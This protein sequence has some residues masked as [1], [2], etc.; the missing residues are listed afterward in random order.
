[1]GVCP[2]AA[3]H[4]AADFPEIVLMEAR[5]CI[6]CG[7]CA[8]VCPFDAITYHPVAAAPEKTAVAIKCD[9]CIE[10]QRQ[11]MI[12][13]CVESCKVEALQFGE[14]NELV[15]A[16]RTRYSEAVSVAMVQVSSEFTPLP[17]NVDA[18][19]HLG[20]EVTHLN[21]NGKKGA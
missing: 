12:P 18:W 2:T 6:A 8:M 10:R 19:R 1:M 14:I 13:A 17:A 3:I 20:A 9:H 11:E 5:K 4:R 21:T 16:A 7:M 15:K